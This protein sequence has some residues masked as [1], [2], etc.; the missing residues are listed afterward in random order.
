M[1]KV[2]F[3]RSSIYLLFTLCFLY[4]CTTASEKVKP[5]MYTVEIKQMKFQPSELTVAKND[6]VVF[7]NKDLVE[8]NV[9]EESN[10]AWT[11][12]SLPNGAS[13]RLVVLNSANYYCTI[14]PVMKGKLK[15]Q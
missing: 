11:S 10:K 1:N 6:T 7:I 9:T 8:H 3:L 4:S 13:W 14:H 12:S 15:I 2:T 5:K